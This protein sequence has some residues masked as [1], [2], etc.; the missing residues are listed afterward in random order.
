MDNSPQMGGCRIR[1]C[2]ISAN[3]TGESLTL[4]GGSSDKVERHL[5]V[6][7]KLRSKWLCMS[8]M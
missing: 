5:G 7:I 8:S 2:D 3:V 6:L 4:L 1:E